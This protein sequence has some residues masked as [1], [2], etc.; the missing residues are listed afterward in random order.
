VKCAEQF[1]S[2]MA[3]RE[4]CR[5]ALHSPEAFFAVR[6]LVCDLIDAAHLAITRHGRIED[7]FPVSVERRRVSGR[8]NWT[9]EV[10]NLRAS[11]TTALW[12]VF[13][14]YCTVLGNEDSLWAF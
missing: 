3:Y 10:V 9:I 8:I 13:G 4:R 11:T 6:H 2:M 1:D 5:L 12:F 14:R 7:C